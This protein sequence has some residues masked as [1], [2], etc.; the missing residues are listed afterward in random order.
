MF[1]C[2]ICLEKEKTIE[3]LKKQNKDLYDRLMAFN[4]NAFTHYKAET[5]S[6]EPLFPHG[7]D[8]KGEPINYEGTDPTQTNQ[9]ILRSMGEDSYSVEEPEKE[10]VKA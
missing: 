3:F 8:A 2:R 5:K 4:E 1:K 10:H 9:E 6:G 7:V